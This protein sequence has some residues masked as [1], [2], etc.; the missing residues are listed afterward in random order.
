MSSAGDLD[1]EAGPTSQALA[2]IEQPIDGW[3]TAWPAKLAAIHAAER[4]ASTGFD[5]ISLAFRDGYN[6]VEPDL[7]TR[8]RAL[9]PRVKLAVGTGRRILR[10]YG[11]TFQNAADNL[12][13][14]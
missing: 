14:H 13:L 4:A 1:M 9:A 8:A 3:G 10:R 2:G 7:S 5:D 11:V 12:N 6:K